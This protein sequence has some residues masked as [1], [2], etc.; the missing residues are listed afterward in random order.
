[1]WLRYRAQQK[2]LGQS[3]PI[4]RNSGGKG[5]DISPGTHPEEISSRWTV[6]WISFFLWHLVGS[7]EEVGIIYALVQNV[8]VQNQRRCDA[9][10]YF[11]RKKSQF[12]PD[13]LLTAPIVDLFQRLSIYTAEDASWLHFGVLF[14]I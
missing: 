9:F 2:I 11:S 5:N 10:F 14:T 4:I 13:E 12:D 3:G 7:G 8:R 1:L 6:I